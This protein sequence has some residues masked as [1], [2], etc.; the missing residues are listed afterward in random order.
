[1]VRIKKF[2]TIV[3]LVYL[4]FAVLMLFFKPVRQSTT[5][6]FGIYSLQLETSFLL[7]LVWASVAI[8]GTLVVFENLDS[9]LL[10]RE[11]T[12]QERKINELKAQLFDAKRATASALPGATPLGPPTYE[13]PEPGS[14]PA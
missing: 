9:G 7:G 14:L 5:S 3:A 8:V 10:R 12:Q 2:I 6:I 13:R 1:M 4:L 11:V